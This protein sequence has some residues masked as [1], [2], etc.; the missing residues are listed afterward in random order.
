MGT[1]V[2]TYINSGHYEIVH[3]QII[4]TQKSILTVAKQGIVSDLESFYLNSIELIQTL[5]R[6][7]QL[8]KFGQLEKFTKDTEFKFMR[9]QSK[10][11]FKSKYLSM[12]SC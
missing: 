2:S 10:S 5:N 11:D 9:T 7:T 1:K 12:Y 4:H 6:A 8:G 3:L